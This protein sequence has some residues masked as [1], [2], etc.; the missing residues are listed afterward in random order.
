MRLQE[1]ARRQAVP[2]TSAWLAHKDPI[3]DQ[4]RI[5]SAAY[6]RNPSVGKQVK[7][8]IIVWI[9]LG[10]PMLILAFILRLVV[11]LL[12]HLIALSAYIAA[13]WNERR[14]ASR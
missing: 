10:L 1:R 11:W 13:A 12:V 7:S 4:Q 6:A 2:A 3:C 9:L 14:K 5:L 8:G